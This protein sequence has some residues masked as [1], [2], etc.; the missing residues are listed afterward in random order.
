[1]I[2]DIQYMRTAEV[3]RKEIEK[4]LFSI[5]ILCRVFGRGKT[6]K[7]LKEKLDLNPEKYSPKK[8]INSGCSRNTCCPLFSRGRS[9]S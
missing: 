1:M 3:L 7:S 5:G 4:E 9:D 8:K 2:F 6:H